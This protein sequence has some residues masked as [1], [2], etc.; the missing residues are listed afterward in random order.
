ML[1]WISVEVDTHCN[2]R[3]TMC[4]IHD[5]KVK[6][7]GRAK[8]EIIER[9]VELAQGWTDKIGLAVMGEPLLHPQAAEMVRVINRGGFKSMLWTNGL[10]VNE[11]RARELLEAKLSKIVFSFEIIDKD[12]HEQI[13]KGASYDKVKENLD[14][15]LALRAELHPATEVSIWNIVPERSHDLIIPEHIREQYRDIEIYCSYAMDWHGEVT[16]DRN[17]EEL[18]DPS[19][20]NQIQRYMAVAWNGD[21]VVCCNDF[22]HEYNLGNLFE[23]SSLDE[24][25][26]G[27]ARL[28]LIDKMASGRLDGVSPCGTCSAPYVKKGVDRVFVKGEEILTGKAASNASKQVA[29]KH[30]LS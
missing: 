11:R 14:R 6:N 15:F 24:I 8:L 17:L 23:V 30:A 12:L 9:L 5:G 29:G 28:E 7:Q 19:P 16:V 10:L 26:F 21:V 3:C 18:G 20:C 4:P 1:E 25:W 13:R 27:S 22:N 2:V